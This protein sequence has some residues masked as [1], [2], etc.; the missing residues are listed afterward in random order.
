MSK[1]A[2]HAARKHTFGI[3]NLMTEI[4]KL[5]AELDAEKAKSS[6]MTKEE[7]SN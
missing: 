5:K 2:L 7:S 4:N 6:D 3:N 1:K